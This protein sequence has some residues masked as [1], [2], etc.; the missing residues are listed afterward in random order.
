MKEHRE[1]A[2]T[3][4][5]MSK[6]QADRCARGECFDR[7]QDGSRSLFRNAYVNRAPLKWT[8]G[9]SLPRTGLF[10]CDFVYIPTQAKKGEPLSEHDF[11]KLKTYIKTQEKQILDLQMHEDFDNQ[12]QEFRP[13]HLVHAQL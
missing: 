7:S 6:L 2:K 11:A 9:Y 13:E 3:L 12:L 10:E 8:P 5:Y 4:L 1:I